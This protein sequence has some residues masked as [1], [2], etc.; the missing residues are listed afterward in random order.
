MSGC[1]IPN[2]ARYPEA[3][4]RKSET[5]DRKELKK[6]MDGYFGRL[7]RMK[8][9]LGKGETA[10]FLDLMAIVDKQPTVE[11]EPRKRGKWEYVRNEEDGNCLYLC[12]VCGSGDIHAPEVTVPYCWKCGAIMDEERKEE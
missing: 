9:R 6:E 2:P 7:Q 10:V 3:P 11:A 1:N 8:K 5:I 4:Q 12:T